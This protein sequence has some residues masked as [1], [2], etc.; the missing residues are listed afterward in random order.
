[1]YGNY[2]HDSISNENFALHLPLF[3]TLAFYNGGRA[4]AC[5]QGAVGSFFGKDE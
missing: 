1:M 4:K 2:F 5:E 3:I